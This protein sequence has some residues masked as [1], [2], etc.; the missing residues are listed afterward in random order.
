MFDV[1]FVFG[2]LFCIAI[3]VS[4]LLIRLYEELGRSYTFE[5]LVDKFKLN[6][7][8]LSKVNSMLIDVLQDRTISKSVFRTLV[9]KPARA[10]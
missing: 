2:F 5:Q 4:I 6:E 10:R 8:E 3:A 7:S 1:N 9:V